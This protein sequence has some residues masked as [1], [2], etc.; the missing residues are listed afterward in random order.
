MRGRES[1]GA[2]G[3]EIERERAREQERV[4][5]EEVEVE[6]AVE[7]F[8]LGG[9]SKKKNEKK[10]ST[11]ESFNSLVEQLDAVLHLLLGHLHGLGGLGV[12]G[13]WRVSAMAR[14]EIFRR[15]S[16]A[17]SLSTAS[18]RR[19]KKNVTSHSHFCFL[20]QT[21][22]LSLLP[23]SPFLLRL[24]SPACDWQMTAP[25]T[26]AASPAEQQQ[27]PKKK[28]CCA[29]PETKVCFSSSINQRKRR[30]RPMPP[31][32]SVFESSLSLPSLHLLF[33]FFRPPKNR[34]AESTRRVRHPPR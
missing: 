24:L 17:R 15:E 16:F 32:L 22:S 10:A 34:V 8:L 5:A 6:V 3:G 2:R 12:V 28:I 27:K 31:S 7:F 25:E 20:S 14:M 13:H 26:A 19:N 33:L 9:R 30:R 4:E 21:N 23:F 29:C 18:V 11:S 1:E